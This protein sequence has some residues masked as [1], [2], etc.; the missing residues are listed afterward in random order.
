R[1]PHLFAAPDLGGA[2]EEQTGHREQRAGEPP[3][4]VCRLIHGN[5]LRR[6]KV[7]GRRGGP[8]PGFLR[9]VRSKYSSHSAAQPVQSEDS[10]HSVS[11]TVTRCVAL[12]PPGDQPCN[13]VSCPAES[14]FQLRAALTR[15]PYAR[16]PG[17]THGK[18]NL[19]SS[20]R[21]TYSAT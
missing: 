9:G 1:D 11:G 12:H 18:G 17:N 13:S 6:H 19:Q 14:G 5:A 8:S 16:S 21:L 10:T 2:E 3:P 7:A 20:C 15:K 4:F